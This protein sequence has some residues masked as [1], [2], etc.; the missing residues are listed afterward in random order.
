MLTP[1]QLEKFKEL[2]EGEI[3]PVIKENEEAFNRFTK[4]AEEFFEN[5]KKG[6]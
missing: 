1:E 6:D 5:E 3:L 4:E 2:F